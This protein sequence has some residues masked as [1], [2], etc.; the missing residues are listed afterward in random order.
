MYPTAVSNCNCIQLRYPTANVSNCGIQSQFVS[1]PMAVRANECA[2]MMNLS[3]QT[4]IDDFDASLHV[5][6]AS[7]SQI[8]FKYLLDPWVSFKNV[9]VLNPSAIYVA[10][11]PGQNFKG[12]EAGK[13]P[14]KLDLE[15]GKEYSFCSCGLSVKQP[16]CDGSE[17]GKGK[18]LMK[19]INFTVDK[20]GEYSMCLCKQSKTMPICDGS[21]KFI[22]QT[23]KNI[24][25]TP[26]FVVV[27]D[28][29]VYEGVSKN[30]GY[31]TKDG[32]Q[33]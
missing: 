13:K 20:S 16:W 11:L 30:L 3:L 7:I 25:A 6:V 2:Q 31:R 21:H 29:A 8:C 4:N 15:V 22:D 5:C 18:T 24:D 28:T 10:S 23:P 12:A 9:K 32:W 33:K 1:N 17:K 19:P 26:K 27:N 14:L